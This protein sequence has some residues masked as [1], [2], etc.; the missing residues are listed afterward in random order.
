MEHFISVVVPLYN[1]RDYIAE[2]IESVRRQDYRRYELVVVDDGSSDGGADLCEELL[3][4]MSEARL[5]RQPNQGA[6]NAINA[7]IRYARG[8]YVAVLNSDDRF[9]PNKLAR[10]NALLGEGRFDLVFGSIGLIDDHGAHVTDGVTVDWLA[11]AHAFLHKT[12]D[13]ALAIANEN[14]A[15][16]TSNMVFSKAIWQQVGGFQD[17]RYCHDLDFLLACMQHG[18]CHY[19]EGQRHVHYRIH[20]RNTIK[21]NLGRIRLEIASV[22]AAAMMESSHGLVGHAMSMGKAAQVREFLDNKS[23]SGL[24]V[25]LMAM[26]RN[27]AGRRDFFA[28]LAKED[29]RAEMID[30]F[31]N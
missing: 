7:G 11:R 24:L 31:L 9:T 13:L 6:H 19:D 28:T 3:A 25:A 4:D 14:F 12:A 17:L 20:Q 8:D 15:T 18:R 22:L 26:Y 10:C 2:T 30:A 5:Y 27:S 29:V 16:T 21:E 1:H 23:M